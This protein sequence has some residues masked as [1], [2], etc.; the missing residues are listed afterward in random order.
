MN[1]KSKLSHLNIDIEENK[2]LS[3]FSTMK[4]KAIGD[5]ITVKDVESLKSLVKIFH[6]E[7]QDFCILG[8]GANTLLEENGVK[9][10]IQI[11]LSFSKDDLVDRG[12]NFVIPASVKLSTLTSFASRNNL[13]RWEIF[14]GV[15]ATLGGAVFMNA[16]TSLGEIGELVSR[17]WLVDREGNERVQKITSDSFSY[18]KNHFVAAGE[19]IYQVELKNLGKDE[20]VS[21]VIRNYLQKRNNSQPLN[22]W[23]CG[24]VFKNAKYN[25]QTCPAGKYIDILGI[26]GLSISDMRISGVHANFMENTGKSSK[27]DVLKLIKLAKE[28]LYLQY[29]IDFELEARID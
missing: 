21:E 28:E 17:V 12:D 10:Y 22:Q 16:G 20:S 19:I 13:R 18:R 14:T 24:C 3:K 25:E 5:L 6:E 7:E 26:K 29:G 1:L 2:D 4:L 9:P 11:K 27:S 8:L 15:P 23:T